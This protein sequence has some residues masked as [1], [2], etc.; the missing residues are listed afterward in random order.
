MLYNLKWGNKLNIVRLLC[1]VHF[2]CLS[3]QYN[4]TSRSNET[5]DEVIFSAQPTPESQKKASLSSTHTFP[6]LTQ[7]H[8]FKPFIFH[9]QV[10]LHCISSI[11]LVAKSGWYGDYNGWAAISKYVEISMQEALIVDDAN[12]D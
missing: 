4:Q 9:R 3:Y 8:W 6:N 10:Y 5:P 12:N 2:I 7:S 11:I 1:C